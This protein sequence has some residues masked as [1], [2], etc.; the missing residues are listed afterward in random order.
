MKNLLL[1]L[2]AVSAVFLAGCN[3][4]TEDPEGEAK[5]YVVDQQGRPIQNA[6]VAFT[7]PVNVP[8][9]LE[10]YKL[11]NIDGSAFVKWDYN[12]Y[13]DVRVT[14]GG[15]SGCT[16]I[17]LVPGETREKELILYPFGETGN[18]CP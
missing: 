2:F 14:K 11:T 4:A 5:V 12:I 18:G 10:V 13:V 3:R 9:G 8:N 6:L 16:A 7:S 15:Y 17:N 1:T